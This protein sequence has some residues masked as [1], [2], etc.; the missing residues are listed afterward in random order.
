MKVVD[1]TKGDG[2][3]LELLVSHNQQNCTQDNFVVT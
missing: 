3:W 1:Y 2:I